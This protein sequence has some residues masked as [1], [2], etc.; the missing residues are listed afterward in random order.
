VRKSEKKSE[1][2]IVDVPRMRVAR[3]HGYGASPEGIAF[4]KMKDWL[5]AHG[6]RSGRPACRVFGFNN[7]NPEPGSTNYGYEFWV[8]LPPD[9]SL[10]R[11]ADEGV[12]TRGFDGGRYGALRHEGP[13]ETIPQTWKRLVGLIG[14]STH[15]HAHHQWLEEHFLDLGSRTEVLILDCLAPI[16]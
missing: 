8:E 6:V 2:R 1:L 4:G 13:G 16:R 11:A 5:S 9:S 15:E 7:P 10:E 14:S 12:E 3:F